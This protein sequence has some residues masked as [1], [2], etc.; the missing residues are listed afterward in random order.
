[1]FIHGDP[2]LRLDRRLA[3]QLDGVYRRSEFY[4]RWLQR[5]TSLG[6]GTQIGRWLT[7]NVTLPFGGALLTVEFLQ[8]MASQVSHKVPLFAPLSM[9]FASWFPG[10]EPSPQLP[11]T[12]TLLFLLLGFFFL[13]LMAVPAV[14]NACRAA[15][16]SLRRGLRRVFV[17]FPS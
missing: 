8:I 7:R 6:F 1:D 9:L 2:L 12:G 10:E 4:L 15:G 3:V 11:V 5:F 16:R 17:D 13:G 14:Q